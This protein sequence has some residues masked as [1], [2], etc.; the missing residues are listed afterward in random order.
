M[1]QEHFVIG[2]FV[3]TAIA[4]MDLLLAMAPVVH[5]VVVADDV[6]VDVVDVVG[7]FFF[8]FL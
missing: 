8:L 2:Y 6:E 1:L 7:L 4:F 3:F 5:V